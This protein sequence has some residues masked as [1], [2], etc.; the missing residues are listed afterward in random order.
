[1]G[2]RDA[3]QQLDRAEALINTAP[4]AALRVLDFLSVNNLN[5]SQRARYGLLYTKAATKN[6]IPLADDSLTCR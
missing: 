3:G 4:D 2:G 5:G 6:H 1:M